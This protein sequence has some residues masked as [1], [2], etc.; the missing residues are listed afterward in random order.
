MPT[1]GAILPVPATRRGYL[2]RPGC[3]VYY[4][5][6]GSGPALVFAHGL[7]SNHLTWWQQVPHFAGR[8][9]CVTFAH[10]GYQPG[11]PI[12]GGP[13]PRE[14]AGDLAALLEQL[15]LADVRLVGQSMGGWTCLEYALAHPRAVRALVL[16]ATCGTIHWPSVPL[17][18]PD[19]LPAWTRQAEAARADMLRRG[20]APPAG[21]RMARE[22]PALHFLYREIAGASDAVDREALRGRLHAM[23]TRS[24]E[25]LR[26]L[27]VPT[28]FLAGD[29][30]TTYPAFLSDALAPLMPDARVELVPG[31][32]HSVYFQQAPRFNWLVEDFLEAAA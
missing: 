23:A 30:D 22:Q 2:E 19:R 8:Y 25:L 13:D 10:R 7:G 15:Q 1:P 3:R 5:A 26:D 4:E 20:I 6:T 32:G 27:G 11:S 29:E 16:A 17:A 18:D 31:A 9:T 21:E 14:F 28:L 12:P 24:P